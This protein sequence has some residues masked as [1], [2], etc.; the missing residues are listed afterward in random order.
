MWELIPVWKREPKKYWERS[1][2][3]VGLTT[4]SPERGKMGNEMGKCSLISP[5]QSDERFL[6][7]L[8]DLIERLQKWPDEAWKGDK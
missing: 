7:L 8:N 5:F 6:A 1:G 2:R 3:G 4:A